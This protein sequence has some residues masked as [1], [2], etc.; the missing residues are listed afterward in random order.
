MSALHEIGDL[1][2]S[3][4]KDPRTS[5][6]GGSTSELDKSHSL[7]RNDPMKSKAIISKG[8]AREEV[9]QKKT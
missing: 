4:I 2:K 1:E 3:K 5:F 6:R 9:T 7:S 8:I